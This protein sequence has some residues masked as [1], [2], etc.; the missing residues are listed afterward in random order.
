MADDI[1]LDDSDELD[2]DKLF[3]D[4]DFSADTEK[5]E[6]TNSREPVE[7][8]LKSTKNVISEKVSVD[9]LMDM[10]SAS[11]SK[12]LPDNLQTANS[13][14][15][16]IREAIAEP[17]MKQVKEIG[18]ETDKLL[19]SAKEALG[20]SD[21][22]FIGGMINKIRDAIR[23]EDEYS[24][25]EEKENVD[26]KIANDV[27]A[28]LEGLTNKEDVATK[29]QNIE[30]LLSNATQEELLT[31]VVSNLNI[32]NDFNI[33][34][35]NS[36]YRKSLELSFKQTLLQDSIFSLLKTNSDLQGKQLEAIVKNTGLPDVIK[37]HNSDHIEHM[38]KSKALDAG[39]NMISKNKTIQN[40]KDNLGSTV[41]EKLGGLLSGLGMG[42]SALEGL[43]MAE[44]A[45]MSKTEMLMDM[46]VSGVMQKGSDVAIKGGMKLL[47]KS[48]LGKKANMSVDKMMADPKN[49][50]NEI[51][52]NIEDKDSLSK[53]DQ[54]A[55]KALEHASELMGGGSTVNDLKLTK[56]NPDD[57]T[58][59]DNKTKT[60][61]T[62]VIPTLLAKIQ[63]E[64]I[65]IRTGEVPKGREIYDYDNNKFT[66]TTKLK[67]EVLHT[68]ISNN[69]SLAKDLNSSDMFNIFEYGE[70]LTPN[71]RKTVKE[72]YLTYLSNGGSTSPY[73]LKAE[74]FFDNFKGKLKTKLEKSV[75][76]ATHKDN[77]SEANR[78]ANNKFNEY[79]SMVNNRINDSTNNLNTTALRLSRMGAGDI[80]EDVG[81]TNTK[82]HT[83]I[84]A[85][86]ITKLNSKIIGKYTDGSV[87]I[88]DYGK[89]T[90]DEISKAKKI[91]DTLISNI[92]KLTD[93]DI[94]DKARKD[95]I[96]LLDK[97]PLKQVLKYET[98]TKKNLRKLVLD[99]SKGRVNIEDTE[100]KS[101][102][103]KLMPKFVNN[104]IE[105]VKNSDTLSELNNKL[106]TKMEDILGIDQVEKEANQVEWT[107]EDQKVN[108]TKKQK[109]NGIYK[110]R[111]VKP[112]KKDKDISVN[113]DYGSYI[114]ISPIT[115]L[116]TKTNDKLSNV[117]KNIYDIRNVITKN[118]IL[119]DMLSTVNKLKR[120]HRYT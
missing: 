65:G 18:G 93:S 25:S 74:G 41:E 45:G 42:N 114:D 61:I 17:A 103:S 115:K 3:D 40:I 97:L 29:K 49:A 30:E 83:K 81:L 15:D 102:L 58:M 95:S 62:N 55:L 53:T 77:N 118:T 73:S 22:S 109:V 4:N 98:Y 100:N 21:E 96:A 31:K 2:I 112:N 113:N 35:A 24:S 1:N 106:N 33:S 75:A 8:I 37:M 5:G 82:D 88:D 78:K 27:N 108:N 119:K 19:G 26:E 56:D 43:D 68:V 90:A 111:K 99:L 44:D 10:G 116:L 6:N 52:K 20:V 85:E 64:L 28:L 12:A 110:E 39:M 69:K 94:S 54:I 72:K 7:N 67:R 84:K 105:R 13:N 104:G 120:N 92:P 71:E 51:M 79:G 47:S 66:D 16:E 60:A 50:I 63:N 14:L 101:M 32:N 59:F 57:L 107:D 87:S 76:L 91:K 9:S 34:V 46:L 117:S 86:N 11:V 70:K 80:L 89:L 38:L 36:Y 23:P 48:S